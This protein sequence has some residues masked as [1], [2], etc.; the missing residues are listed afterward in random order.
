M[1]DDSKRKE[2]PTIKWVLSEDGK[3]FCTNKSYTSNHFFFL[4]ASIII[5]TFFKLLPQT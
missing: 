3:D 5:T 2:N 1:K 4:M